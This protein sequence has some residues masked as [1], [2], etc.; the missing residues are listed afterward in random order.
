MEDLINATTPEIEDVATPAPETNEAETD[1]SE[2]NT[3]ET[4]EVDESEEV[5]YKGKTYK[6][7]RDVAEL[8]KKAENLDGDYTRKMQYVSDLRKAAESELQQTRH[9]ASLN[10]QIIQDVGQLRSIESRLNEYQNVNWQAWFAQNPQEAMT[11]QMEYTQLKDGHSQLKGHVESRKS[12]IEAMREQQSATAHS[13][14]MTE[15]SKPDPSKGWDGKFDSAKSEQL[16]KFGLEIGFTAEELR[17]TTHPMMIKALNLA[18]IGAETLK[19]QKAATTPSVTVANPIPQIGAR[20]STPPTTG[21]S[22]NLSQAEWLK[23][24]NSQVYGKK[25]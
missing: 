5:A 3:V 4:V 6:V 25:T 14:A 19:K 1:D 11:A 18:K 22:D 17:N 24:R 10:D 16:T 13:Q 12:E 8:L 20:K 7:D 9:E 15:L 23:R 21:L 2:E